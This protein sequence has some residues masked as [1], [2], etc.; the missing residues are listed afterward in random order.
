VTELTPDEI[1]EAI[2]RGLEATARRFADRGP[3]QGGGQPQPAG[4]PQGQVRRDHGNLE[5]GLPLDN[6]AELIEHVEGPQHR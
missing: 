4:D 5:P 2:R 1:L 6:V 3:N